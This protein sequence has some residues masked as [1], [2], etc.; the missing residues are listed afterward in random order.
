MKTKNKR[1]QSI[2][3]KLVAAIC[4]LLVSSIMMVS[5]TY[6]WFTLSTAPEVTGITTSVGANGS[7]EMALLPT[8][9]NASEIGSAVG[10]SYD[11]S[12]FKKANNTWGN[13][14]SMLENDGS[15]IYG[16]DEITLLPSRLNISAGATDSDPDTIQMGAP[17]KTPS[18]GADG[19]V[20]A[21]TANTSAN[22]ADENGKFF[23]VADIA[24]TLYGVRAVGTASAM[25]DRQLGYRN[26]RQTASTASSNARTIAAQALA[27]NGN[28]LAML[29][30]THA[31]GEDLYYIADVEAM[32]RIA[33]AFSK[34]DGVIDQIE[35]ALTSY[36]F[37]IIASGEAQKT[38]SDDDYEDFMMANESKT[39]VELVA[40]EQVGT[41][42]SAF[43]AATNNAWT[44]MYTAY[45]T[46]ETNIASAE[47][48][49]DALLLDDDSDGI[50]NVAG[51]KTV[52]TEGEGGPTTSTVAT[53]TWD[54]VRPVMGY[55]A[56]P[57]KMTVNGMT[58]EEITAE[59]GLEKFVE[60]TAEYGYTVNMVISTGGGVFADIA[61]FCSDY[62]TEF[63]LTKVTAMG[64]D[65]KNVPAYMTT[66][67]KVN[68]TYLSILSTYAVGLGAPA[69]GS[70]EGATLTDMYGYIVDL[71]FR[72][73]ASGA[74]LLLQTEG[75]DRIYADQ[76][77]E[78]TGTLGHGSTMSFKGSGSFTNAQVKSLMDAI[79]VVFFDTKTGEVYGVAKLDTAN[80]ITDGTNGTEV[81][82]YLYLYEY[83][84]DAGGVLRV[85][86]NLKKGQSYVI[87][88]DTG[89]ATD[90]VTG[91]ANA[92]LKS[93][94][95]NLAATISVM[96]YLDGDEV[97]NSDVA[98][99]VA[100]SMTGSLN[101]QFS[102]SATL[103]PMDYTPLQSQGGNNADGGDDVGN[104]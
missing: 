67:T 24:K 91:T 60:K 41:L 73:N 64:M 100:T 77:D 47:A 103:V 70:S 61:D 40:V 98:A 38:I 97:E 25:S 90:T 27:I 104:N 76:E 102:T 23:A 17:L 83:S 81:S 43:D 88:E 44:T 66:E 79:N 16:L 84:I 95:Q 89:L 7:L 86:T 63:K 35:T 51:T 9:G 68:P 69:A 5:S 74:D 19:R 32:D 53:Y 94:T 31:T 71:A 85:N 80:L 1:Q 6:A 10:D 4:M 93:L 37:A 34:T 13:L 57:N 92:T 59:G 96:V 18:Y 49:I 62:D 65:L 56:D 15:D 33:A 39:L 21:L 8:H 26:F 99:D 14:V 3:N 11:G 52:T 20:S 12:S 42:L 54:Q 87:D 30:I 55:F 2:K 78:S 82:A 29:A 48:A 22:A 50:P 58:T 75:I 28:D 46:L 101:L 72:T 36:I 45:Q